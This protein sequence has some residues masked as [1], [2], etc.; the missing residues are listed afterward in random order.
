[1]LFRSRVLVTAGGSDP[2]GLL[3]EVLAVLGLLPGEFAVTAV[4]GP[5]VEDRGG[6]ERAVHASR[7]SVQLAH[8]PASLAGLMQEADLAVSGGGQTLY[9]LA[10]MGVPTVAVEVAGNQ[11]PSL[12]ALAAQG[13]VHCAGRATDPDLRGA[14]AQAV[15]ELLEDHHRREAMSAAGRRLVDGRGAQRVANA[16]INR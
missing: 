12:A 5:F 4:V 8:A 11:A 13:V 7:R 6:I 10:A 15:A 1:M 14:L 16:V 2:Q 3:P 9:E